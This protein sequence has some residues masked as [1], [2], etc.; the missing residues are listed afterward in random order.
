MQYRGQ[1]NRVGIK[2]PGAGMAS[3]PGDKNDALFAMIEEGMK[4]LTEKLAGPSNPS[5]LRAAVESLG[6]L[7][8]TLSLRAEFI[9]RLLDNSTPARLR[10]S[11]RSSVVAMQIEPELAGRGMLSMSNDLIEKGASLIAAAQERINK[12]AHQAA[13]YALKSCGLCKGDSGTPEGSC[14]VCKGRGSLVVREPAAGCSHCQGNGLAVSH[15]KPAR[16]SSLCAACNGTGWVTT[17]G[18]SDRE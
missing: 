10:D 16:Y 15:G 2:S 6:S 11:L 3:E 13:G 1:Q 17:G 4:S 14:V 8:E 18:G 12:E 9:A 5:E 7:V